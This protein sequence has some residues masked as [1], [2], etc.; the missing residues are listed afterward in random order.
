MKK[1]SQDFSDLQTINKIDPETG[2]LKITLKNSAKTVSQ[3]V[4]LHQI[5]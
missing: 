1:A 4:S 5:L 3:K 2:K